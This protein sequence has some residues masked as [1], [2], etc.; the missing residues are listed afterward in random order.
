MNKSNDLRFHVDFVTVSR[1]SP[2]TTQVVCSVEE[3][4]SL[5]HTLKEAV[6]CLKTNSA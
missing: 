4:E 6:A 2:S 3:L 5:V 1:D